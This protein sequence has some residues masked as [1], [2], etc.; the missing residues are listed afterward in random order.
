MYDLPPYRPPSESRSALI[1]VIRG[2]PWNRCAFC[3]MYKD[4]KCRRRTLEDI[5]AD[6]A[7]VHEVFP[8]RRTVFLGDSE[9]L[10]HKDILKV[11]ELVSEAFPAA[12]R[13]TAYARAHSLARRKLDDL[14]AMRKAGLT[15]VHVGLESGDPEIL[16]SLK[17]GSDPETMI[18]AGRLVREAG[19]ELCFYVLCGVGG[20]DRWREH[21]DET[22]KV[23]NAVDP[24]FIRLRTLT[25]IPTAPLYGVWKAGG[26]Q[27][28]AAVTRLRETERLIAG[29]RVSACRLAS[30]HM[31]NNLWTPEG[32]VYR[33]VDG[34]LP[35][36][37]AAMLAVLTKAI[38]EVS[39]RTDIM[40]ANALFQK[41]IMP[42]L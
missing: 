5:A 11:L 10:L 29:L 2:C 28:V 23:I 33:G 8:K 39:G 38:Q 37:K 3:G 16:K 32:C 17:K 21:A 24:D 22:A 13:V 34:S 20:E 41:G 6:I 31:T 35:R 12:E 7:R 4:L 40:D 15:R 30:D 1:R 19:I 36:D 27:P 18:K 25:L 26:F 42:G 9:P 14:K